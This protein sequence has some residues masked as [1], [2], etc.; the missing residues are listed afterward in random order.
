MRVETP[1][2]GRRRQPATP[3]SGGDSP[4]I[5]EVSRPSLSAAQTRSPVDL[6]PVGHLNR[7]LAT[8]I[9]A[10]AFLLGFAPGQLSLQ[11][12]TLTLVGLLRMT[13]GQAFHILQGGLI[14]YAGIL[15]DRADQLVM[16]KK[17]RPSTWTIYLGVVV[18][19]MVEV[20]L[21]A[22]AVFVAFA[23]VG[24]PAPLVSLPAPAIAFV[25]AAMAGLLLAHRALKTQCDVLVLRTHLLARQRLPAPVAVPRHRVARPFLGRV[26][27]RDEWLLAWVVCIATGQAVLFMLAATALGVLWLLEGLVMLHR[28]LKDPEVLASKV[29]G[30]GY[31]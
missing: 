12:L 9:A 14:A 25:G 5:V 15:L 6:G 31:P 27:G 11:S 7:M 24:L 17:G 1:V 8:P 26:I 16:E 20:A 18:D 28:H 29:L 4:P 3:F 30:P 2:S 10:V 13:D 21:C 22:A 19:R 23:G